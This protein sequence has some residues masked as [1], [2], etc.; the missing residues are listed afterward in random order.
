MKI[1]VTGVSGQL[2]YDVIKELQLRNIECMGAD[3][4]EFDFTNKQATNDYIKAYNPDAV[5]HCGAYTAVDKAEDE[6]DLCMK[7]NVDGTYNIAR[8]CKEIHASLMYI[9]TDYVFDGTKKGVYEVCDQTNP[10]NVYGKSKLGGEEVI[11]DLL[12]NNF[13]VRISWAFGV[14]GNNFIKTMLRLAQENPVI[15]VVDDQ[16]GSPTYTHDL[17]RLLCDMIVTEK[18]GTYHATNSGT[19]SWYEFAKQ[20]FSDA[21]KKTIV[22]PVSS[23]QYKTKAKRPRNSCLSKAKLSEAGFE[24]LRDWHEALAEYI[25]VLERE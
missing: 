11:R 23:K 25:K 13:I 18:Y 1:L 7:V 20:I 15:N 21:G 6:P 12:E 16:F 14:N 19:C 17:A 10:Q 5:I 2:G 8:V 24:P 3:R 22:N 4:N 9:S